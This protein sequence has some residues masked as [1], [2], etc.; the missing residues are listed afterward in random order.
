MKKWPHVLVRSPCEWQAD[1]DV[2]PA[3]AEWRYHTIIL[4]D[5]PRRSRSR[6]DVG[7]VVDR[8]LSRRR[9]L[10]P[11]VTA[12]NVP[13]PLFQK[14]ISVLLVLS[15]FLSLF[16]LG[17]TIV[18]YPLTFRHLSPSKRG[19]LMNRACWLQA[20]AFSSELP[21]TL[22]YIYIDYIRPYWFFHIEYIEC[23]ICRLYIFLF[24][25]W[26]KMWII[27]ILLYIF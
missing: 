11:P 1:D 24:I 12:L 21:W 10:G 14:W 18:A 23:M 7:A 6:P 5:A 17:R 19:W 20:S 27:S 4:V 15:S 9:R 8:S 22:F 2:P 25:K 16:S 3:S 13:I 26:R